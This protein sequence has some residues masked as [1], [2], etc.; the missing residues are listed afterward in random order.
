MG[1]T[2]TKK[3]D[4]FMSRPLQDCDIQNVPGVGPVALGKL[5]DAN[6]DTAEKL[7]GHFLLLGRD[8]E[9]MSKWLQD[10]CEIRMQESG[11]VSE[12]LQKKAAKIVTL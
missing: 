7:V 6:I 3:F 8:T 2:T 4:D 5:K 11:K 12:A 1:E 10:V 9:K